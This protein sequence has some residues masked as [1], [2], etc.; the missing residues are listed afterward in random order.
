M[1]EGEVTAVKYT[2]RWPGDK[3]GS[4]SIMVSLHDAAQRVFMLAFWCLSCH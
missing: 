1:G 2:V 4:L 3:M